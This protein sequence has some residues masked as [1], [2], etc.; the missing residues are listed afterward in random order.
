MGFLTRLLTGSKDQKAFND[1]LDVYGKL[2]QFDV[3]SAPYR[4]ALLQ[5]LRH[6]QTAIALNNRNGD[7]HVLLANTFLL[8]YV[9]MNIFA[10][11]EEPLQLAAAVIQHWADEPM[12]Q[13]PWTKNTDNGREIHRQVATALVDEHPEMERRLDQEMRTLASSLYSS[14]LTVN[15]IPWTVV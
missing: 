8:F 13:Y 4:R 3:Q 1:A 6:C 5:V 12:R 15:P 11:D 14:A 2:R 10:K 7:A 9:D